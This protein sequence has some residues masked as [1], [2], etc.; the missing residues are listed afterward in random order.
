M[1][2]DTTPA[3]KG[4]IR[5]LDGRMDKMDGSIQ[6]L[7][8]RMDNLD[9]R[10]DK[11]DGSIHR[12]DGRIDKLDTKIDRM[13]VDLR[14]EMRD[15]AKGLHTAIDQ[16]LTVLVNVDKR[17]TASVVDHEKRITKLETLAGVSA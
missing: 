16:V 4:D 15:M 5:H 14:G 3:T 9:A 13:A 7:D 8:G 10:M 11:M 12:L 2:D 6:R 1:N 17:L